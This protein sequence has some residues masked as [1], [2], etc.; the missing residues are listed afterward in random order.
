MHGDVRRCFQFASNITLFRVTQPFFLQQQGWILPQTKP[1]DFHLSY[2]LNLQLSFW[3]NSPS[4]WP[5]NRAVL[6]ENEFFFHPYECCHLLTKTI[7]V[8]AKVYFFVK[9]VFSC[10]YLKLLI[11]ILTTF[12]FLGIFVPAFFLSI[13]IL[14][15]SAWK[16]TSWAEFV[17]NCRANYSF[18]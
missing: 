10:H 6:F 1:R 3:V 12:R 15:D 2:Q 7:V 11:P 5:W 17:N 4:T 8:W 18:N 13:R 9:N 16:W 14:K